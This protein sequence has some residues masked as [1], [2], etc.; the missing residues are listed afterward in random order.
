MTTLSLLLLATSLLFT[1]NPNPSQEP[2]ELQEANT[3]TESAVRLFNQGS[4]NEALPLAKR[5]L[6][7]RDKL[8]PQ[9][10]PRIS[11][12][13]TNLGEIYFAQKDYKPAREIFQRLLKIQEEV[14]GSEDVNLAFTLDRLAVL[15]FAAGNDRE[16]EVAYKRA[17]AL[18]EKALGVDDVQ[19]AQSWFQLGEFYRFRRQLQ[20][21]LDSYRRSLKLYGKLTGSTTPEFERASDGFACLGYDHHKPELLQELMEIRAQFPSPGAVFG[22]EKGMLLN[23]R[24]L[25]MPQP[26]Y[27]YAARARRLEGVVIVKVEID[28]TGKVIDAKDM[29]QGP[30]YL[31]ESSVAAAR[32]ARFAPVKLDGQPMKVIG[33]L[34]YKFVR[35]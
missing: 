6:E 34:Q 5:A 1:N 20:P 31:S 27:P 14:F 13:L 21:A 29:C 28:E 15:Y 26:V 4:Y 23:S 7:I 24:A 17:L 3:L 10:D 8:L 12:S 19:V 32:K 18:R 25:T 16:T 2:P 33:V 35:Q 11:S 9:T 22:T 30:P